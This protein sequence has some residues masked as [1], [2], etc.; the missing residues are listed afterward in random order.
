MS[1]QMV[2]IRVL[3]IVLP[4]IRHVNQRI[5]TCTIQIT[6]N[7]GLELLLVEFDQFAHCLTK[8][9]QQLFGLLTINQASHR[10]PP[11]RPNTSRHPMSIPYASITLRPTFPPARELESFRRDMFR[12]ISLANRTLSPSLNHLII[13]DK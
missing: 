13:F 9:A 2:K 8:G 3:R 11:S 1:L 6:S 4:L 12:K 7:K 5:E 10:F